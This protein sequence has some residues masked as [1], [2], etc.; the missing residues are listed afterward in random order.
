VM[1]AGL[2]ALGRRGAGDYCTV[3]DA[4]STSSVKEGLPLTDR[5]GCPDCL[6]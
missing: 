1:G 3:D 2:Q 5:R 4:L 6:D